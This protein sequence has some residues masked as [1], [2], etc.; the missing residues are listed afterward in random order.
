MIL[1]RDRPEEGPHIQHVKD[2]KCH[3][4]AALACYG[5]VTQ[6]DRLAIFGNQSQGEV[7]SIL[8]LPIIEQLAL[9]SD[10]VSVLPNW[11]TSLDMIASKLPSKADGTARSTDGLFTASGKQPYGRF[12]ELRFGIEA[13]A[14]GRFQADMLSSVVK[15]WNLP[16][17]EREELLVLLT[18]PMASRILRVPSG[19]L[20]RGTGG[21]I[22]EI[23]G[24]TGLDTGSRT[25]TAAVVSDNH[26]MQITE[27]SISITHAGLS[28]VQRVECP[29][30]FRISAAAIDDEHGIFVTS[31]VKDG[32]SFITLSKILMDE[33]ETTF[34]TV[35]TP[36]T[37]REELISV[38]I[39]ESSI[40]MFAVFGSS[41]ASLLFYGLD[42]RK[43]PVFVTKSTVRGDNNTCCA[44]DDMTVLVDS[45]QDAWA[46]GSRLVLLCGLRDGNL[47]VFE[48]CVR[49]D[50]RLLQAPTKI[51]C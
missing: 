45:K 8:P 16:I 24:E 2:F 23:D 37:S 40:G 10:L 18:S 22:T 12:W 38:T 21:D 33:E 34:E 7:Y 43:G 11:D 41:D 14:S 36:T 46:F 4:G 19:V 15:L 5:K 20:L 31:T 27:R 32:Q 6:N 1:G 49:R 39:F 25:L 9:D 44:C 48:L 50:G 30:G 47:R 17:E 42:P 26:V 3:I 35:G 13:C 51:G 29:P 28:G